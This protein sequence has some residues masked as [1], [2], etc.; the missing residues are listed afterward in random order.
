MGW[1][2]SKAEKRAQV[3]YFATRAVVSLFVRPTHPLFVN[4]LANWATSLQELGQYA[5]ARPLLERSLSIRE[6][7][8]GPD[9]RELALG[10]IQLADCLR[11]IGDYDS[12][13]RLYERA[14]A[15]YEKS[16]G[17]EN[18]DLAI[19]Q[20]HLAVL[21]GETGAT[22]LSRET[23]LRAERIIEEHT[24]LT[25]STLAEQEALLY[26][27]EKPPALDLALTLAAKGTETDAA[28]RRAVFDALIRSRALVLDTMA[29]RHR[30]VVGTKDPEV[31]RLASE[32]AAARENLAKLVVRGPGKDPPERYKSLLHDARQEKERAERSLA[33]KSLAFRTEHARNRVSLEDVRAAL[34]SNSGL[35][36]FVRYGSHALTRQKSPGKPTEPVPSYSAFVLRSGESDAKLVT[37]GTAE[38]IDVAVSR[39][40]K[41]VAQEASAVGRTSQRSEAAYRQTAAELRQKVW[42]PLTPHLQGIKRVFLVPDGARI[43]QDIGSF[44]PGGFVGRIVFTADSSTSST[45]TFTWFQQGNGGGFPM[46]ATFT[47][48]YSVN[49][50]TS[51][52]PCTGMM[53]RNEDGVELFFTIVQGGEEIDFA[54]Y[55]SQDPSV[56]GTRVGQ[57]VMKRQ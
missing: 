41:Q 22:A 8:F 2:A 10:M 44:S 45:G 40:Q 34:P 56:V 52:E 36:A 3:W 19:A 50:E 29:T 21:L 26:V 37:L 16:L 55:T 57:G 28:F 30:T 33:E 1:K 47:G 27:S 11:N 38:E 43:L 42:D 25:S 49:S 51:S 24:R 13:R 39:W 14:A 12:A 54:F 53:T 31:S 7:V 23:V 35:V 15:A 5:A 9:H 46:T 4:S 18:P 48:T 17:P 32:L 6:K 20:Y